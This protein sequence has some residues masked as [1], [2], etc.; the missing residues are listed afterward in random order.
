MLATTH[1]T[2]RRHNPED[3]K[4]KTKELAWGTFLS[5]ESFETKQ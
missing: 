4:T 1:K 5:K 2:A 3:H